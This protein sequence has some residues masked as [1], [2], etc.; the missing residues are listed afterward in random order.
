VSCEDS[1]YIS[2]LKFSDPRYVIS[3]LLSDILTFLEI[4]PFAETISV[5][6]FFFYGPYFWR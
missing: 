2:L 3:S 4:R 1:S 5:L 6:I